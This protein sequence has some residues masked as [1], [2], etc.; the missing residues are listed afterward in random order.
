MT[1][2]KKVTTSPKRECKV[3]EQRPWIDVIVRNHKI[4]KMVL[5]WD[6]LQHMHLS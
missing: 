3:A 2:E 5:K 1:R 4:S 6:H